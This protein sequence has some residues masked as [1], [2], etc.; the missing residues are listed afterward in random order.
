MQ[1]TSVVFLL[2]L[3]LDRQTSFFFIRNY[4]ADVAI[5]NKLAQNMIIRGPSRQIL[6]ITT[7]GYEERNEKLKKKYC[8]LCFWCAI[9][10]RNLCNVGT[11]C[12]V[13][14]YPPYST[15]FYFIIIIFFV[16]LLLLLLFLA[17]H[18]V[19]NFIHYFSFDYEA[20]GSFSTF[21]NNILYLWV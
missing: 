9:F 13:L 2:F 12:V 18:K 20:D 21:I 11:V 16:C 14:L 19:P 17:L 3:P 10:V 1:S 15:V 6:K 8:N 4:L 5:V 7:D